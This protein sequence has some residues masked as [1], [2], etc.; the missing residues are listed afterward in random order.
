MDL[1]PDITKMSTEE[2]YA[3]LALIR[4]NRRQRPAESRKVTATKAT[5][6]ATKGVTAAQLLGGLSEEDKKALKEMMK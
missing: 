3:A 6:A 1:K 5:K 2:L 4:H